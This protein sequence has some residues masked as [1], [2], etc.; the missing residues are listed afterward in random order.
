M[1]ALFNGLRAVVQY[2]GREDR[3]EAGPWE[4]TTM[5]AFDSLS[6]AERY[7][8]ECASEIWEYRALPVDRE[9]A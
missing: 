9:D 8:E 4:W 5:A 1:S 7:A 3:P 6:M 2:R